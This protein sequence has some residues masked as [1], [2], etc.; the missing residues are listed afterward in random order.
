M[1][2]RRLMKVS[3]DVGVEEPWP[4]VWAASTAQRLSVSASFCCIFTYSCLSRV[5]C[6][7]SLATSSV[8]HQGK[9]NRQR[10]EQDTK[11]RLERPF[12]EYRLQ[13]VTVQLLFGIHFTLKWN[14]HCSLKILALTIWHGI[15]PWGVIK[16]WAGFSPT[17]IMVWEMWLEVLLLFY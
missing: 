9:G 6:F 11:S 8:P 14:D 15:K 16:M 17:V 1:S 10:T 13:L 12:S 3:E 2:S 7:C 5:R 4:D